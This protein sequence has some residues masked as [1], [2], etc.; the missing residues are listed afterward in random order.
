MQTQ[1][2]PKVSVVSHLSNINIILFAMSWHIN[3]Y[4]TKSSVST[5]DPN[6]NCAGSIIFKQPLSWF[7]QLSG[8]PLQEKIYA[9]IFRLFEIKDQVKY[10]SKILIITFSMLR[11]LFLSFYTKPNNMRQ[12]YYTCK[13]MQMKY[14]EKSNLLFWDNILPFYFNNK[15][16]KQRMEQYCELKTFCVQRIIKNVFSLMPQSTQCP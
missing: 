3:N 15:L 2:L 10:L 1:L 11:H 9:K 8:L 14:W 12:D 7:S 6:E 16:R 4:P 13:Y 5:W